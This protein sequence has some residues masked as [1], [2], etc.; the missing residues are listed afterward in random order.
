[1]PREA[2]GTGRGQF[3]S[4]RPSALCSSCRRVSSSLT[5]F[6]WPRARRSCPRGPLRTEGVPPQAPRTDVWTQTQRCKTCIPIQAQVQ[7]HIRSVP[8]CPRGRSRSHPKPLTPSLTSFA[9][10]LAHARERTAVR[11][12]KNSLPLG[13]SKMPLESR[14]QSNT[15]QNCRGFLELS[16]GPNLFYNKVRRR[17]NDPVSATVCHLPLPEDS[18]TARNKMVCSFPRL[19]KSEEMAGHMHQAYAPHMEKGKELNGE[20]GGDDSSWG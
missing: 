5:G 9:S 12:K 16:R 20:W 1:M 4:Q 13:L 14:V 7:S 2:G 3:L 15:L 11:Q 10:H 8:P 17:K 6:P 18:Y 19:T